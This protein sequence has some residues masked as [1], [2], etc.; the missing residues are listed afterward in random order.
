MMSDAYVT[1]M[2]SNMERSIKFYIKILGFKLRS[3]FGNKWADVTGHGIT[4]GLHPKENKKATNSGTVS[5]G[6]SVKNLDK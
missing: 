2:V 5:I 4:I 1:I 3:R 6:F